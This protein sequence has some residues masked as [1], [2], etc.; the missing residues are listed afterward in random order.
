MRLCGLR[1]GMSSQKSANQWVLHDPRLWL[2]IAFHRLVE[3]VR[4]GLREGLAAAWDEEIARLLHAARD[5]P[6]DRRYANPEEWPGYQLARIRSIHTAERL[7]GR[8]AAGSSGRSSS[9]MSGFGV[10]QRLAARGGKLVG[11]PDEYSPQRVTDYKSS[12]PQDD[13]PVR[14]EIVARFIRQ[15]QIYAAIIAEAT[16]Q[17]V[18]EGVIHSGSGQ[19][20]SFPLVP[21][22]CDQEADTA[23][24]LLSEW[25]RRLADI[26]PTALANVAAASCSSCRFQT[27]CPAFWAQLESGGLTFPSG[28]VAAVG[29]LVSVQ[30]GNDADIATLNFRSLCSTGGEVGTPAIVIRQSIHGGGLTSAV[31]STVRVSNALQRSDGRLRAD[32]ATVFL[33]ETEAP[34]IVAAS[35]AECGLTAEA[36]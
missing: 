29:T 13:S 25:N 35:F 21:L 18:K 1:A 14:N 34:N 6:L 4:R 31:G 33:A 9:P 22:D 10:E 30:P 17:W 20:I 12:I 5:H 32:H 23:V 28:R 2:G 26:G 24:A 8:R 11:R 15:L 3:R 7:L 36:E 19:S 16:G 27:I